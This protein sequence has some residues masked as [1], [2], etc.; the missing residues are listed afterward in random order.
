VVTR[1]DDADITGRRLHLTRLTVALLVAV[2]ATSVSRL[3]LAFNDHGLIWPDEI[4]QSV[5]PAHRLVFGYGFLSWEYQE[6]L[7]SWIWPGILS[8]VLWIGQALGLTTGLS[9]MV[10]VKIF[11]ALVAVGTSVFGVLLANRLAGGLAAI[12]A[13]AVIPLFPLAM[14]LDNHSFSEPFVALL[15]VAS[16]YYFEGS[17][18][19]SAFAA[20]FLAVSAASLR[21]QVVAVA[22]AFVVGLLLRRDR[23]RG[24]YVVAGAV[25]MAALAGLLD[26]IT[27]GAPFASYVNNIRY[28]LVEGNASLYGEE[29]IGYY[30]EHLFLTGGVVFLVALVGLVFGARRFAI[31]VSGVAATLVLHTLVPHKELRFL[32]PIVAYALAVAAAGWV[33][34]LRTDEPIM[35]RVAHPRVLSLVVVACLVVNLFVAARLTMG[36]LG[37]TRFWA[38]SSPVWGNNESFNVQSSDIGQDPSTCGLAF[39]DV[40]FIFVGGYSYFHRDVPYWTVDGSAESLQ[41]FNRVLADA[42]SDPIGPPFERAGID[43]TMSSWS[44]PGSC[45]GT[46]PNFSTLLR[47]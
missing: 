5:E 14:A 36:N 15:L 43:S 32:L 7:R 6:G 41:S 2:T 25:L 40:N 9:L 26:W 1:A 29:S 30:V 33:I 45:P 42:Y 20:G 19:G 23:A 21:L 22:V 47:E 31:H 46:P 18:R 24:Y 16:A 38:A 37:E 13:A 39:V 12:F 44:R 27:W 11:L 4:Y 17:T 35:E 3:W 10:A 34:R 8:V 28:N